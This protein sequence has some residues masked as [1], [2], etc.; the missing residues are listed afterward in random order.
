MYP[1]LNLKNNVTQKSKLQNN[2]YELFRNTNTYVVKIY[3]DY[4]EGENGM[5]SGASTEL[6]MIIS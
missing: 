4:P 3:G 1:E 2:Y 6:V 5:P